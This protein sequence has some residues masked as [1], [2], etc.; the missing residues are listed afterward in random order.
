MIMLFYGSEEKKI[1]IQ[2]LNTTKRERVAWMILAMLFQYWI[3]YELTA[4]VAAA[5]KAGIF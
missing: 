4:A 1:L 2:F 3:I 5:A